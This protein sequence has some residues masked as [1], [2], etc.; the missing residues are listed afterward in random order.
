MDRKWSSSWTDWKYPAWMD[1]GE[2]RTGRWWIAKKGEDDGAEGLWR[3]H[4]KLY[5]LTSWVNKHPGGK[6]WITLTKGLDITEAYESSHLNQ[7]VDLILQKFYVRDAKTP[8]NSPYT[9]EPGGFFRTLKSRVYEEMK[10]ME[11]GTK[12]RSYILIDSLVVMTFVMA[13]TAVKF[14]NYTAGF[15]SAACLTGASIAAHNFFHQKDNWRMYYFQLSL[16]S[17]TD[18]RITHSLSHHIYTNTY[19]DLELMMME[20]FLQWLPK[21]NKNWLAKNFAWLYTPVVYL[22]VYHGQAL[23]RI[24]RHGVEWQDAI[25]L[26]TPT[27]MYLFSGASLLQ[28]VGM[29]SFIM[30]FSSVMFA[31]LGFN[32]AHHHPDIFHE[33]DKPRKDTDWGLN[34]LDA[35]GERVEVKKTFPWSHLSFGDHALHHIFPTIDHDDLAQLY[36]VFERTCQEFNVKLSHMTTWELILGQFKQLMRTKG[37]TT[38]P[39]ERSA[40]TRS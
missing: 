11:T 34:Q 30:L 31:T 5:D 24:L 36:P 19:H 40:I 15:I 10:T 26:A 6:Q 27:I 8:R 20:P 33:G 12:M 39:E 7:D 21:E 28:C 13:I 38:S 17:V 3:V 23:I 4:D 1:G 37:N 14:H 25:G 35:V 16:M 22:S 29:W 2:V 18:W 9:M 32:A